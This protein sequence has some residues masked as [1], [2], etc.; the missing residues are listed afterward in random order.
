MERT[1]QQAMEHARAQAIK[2]G[3]LKATIHPSEDTFTPHWSATP[4]FINWLADQLEDAIKDADTV[5]T[6]R[7]AV[8]VHTTRTILDQA[9]KAFMEGVD[10]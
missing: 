6:E 3:V 8:R 10:E 2:F 9:V 1:N 7:A 4:D 5:N